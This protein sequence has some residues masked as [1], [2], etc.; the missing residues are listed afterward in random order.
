MVS[1]AEKS[2]AT[3]LS[4]A[5][6]GGQVVAQTTQSRPPDYAVSRLPPNTVSS[7]WELD[8]IFVAYLRVV[9]SVG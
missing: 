3:K 5:S 6:S 2:S 1:M 7:V 4:S 9:R 8:L